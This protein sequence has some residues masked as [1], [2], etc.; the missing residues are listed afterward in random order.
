M[1][2]TLLVMIA[3]VSGEELIFCSL[4]VP[5]TVEYSIP[6]DWM[7]EPL[8]SSDDWYVLEQEGG[9][10]TIIPLSLD[11]LDLPPLAAISDFVEVLFPPPVLQVTRT[12]PDTVWTV[13][14]FPSP[15]SL[16]IPPGFPENYL[17][18]HRF[19]EEWGKVPADRW[20]LPVLLASI[21]AAS[22][23]ILWF[24]HLRRKKRLITAENLT[25][26]GH[27]LSPLEEVKTLLD[28]PAFANG[29]WK[30]F[31]RLVDRM[32][33]DTISFR[34]GIFNRA[35]TMRQIIKLVGREEEGKKFIEESS[36]LTRETAL[37]RYASWG[38]SRE[39]AGRFISTLLSIRREWH[40]R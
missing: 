37:Q 10:V 28:T 8:E 3:L 33:R 40:R 14:V 15:L 39:R 11:T 26:E 7:T 36:E 4:G 12:M 25:D 27:M 1:I 2:T 30:E 17:N 22:V 35:L 31:Y 32:L 13:P 29:N 20:F 21:I 38:S 16:N 19:W 34:F 18:Q 23:I 6:E 5:V 9:R 24:V